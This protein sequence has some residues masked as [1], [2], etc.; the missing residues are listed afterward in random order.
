MD[1]VSEPGQARLGRLRLVHEP[2]RFRGKPAGVAVRARDAGSDD[3]HAQRP[4]AAVLVADRGDAR[5]DGGGRRLAV[6]G[7]GEARGGARRR[8]RAVI[9]AAD[10]DRVDEPPLL[11]RRETRVVEQKDQIGERRLPHQLEHVVAAHAQMRRPGVYD[12]RPQRIHVAG[13]S[14]A[15]CPVTFL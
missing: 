7:G 14:L 10:Q 15:R 12:R 6:P 4:G 9:G 8:A 1:A 2:C 13:L 3:L 5:G 11:R